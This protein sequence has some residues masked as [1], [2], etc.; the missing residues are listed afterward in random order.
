MKSKKLSP[1]KNIIYFSVAAVI[2]ILLIVVFRLSS[3]QNQNRGSQSPQVNRQNCLAEDCLLIDDLNY[4]AG[5]LSDSVKNSLNEAINDEYKAYSTYEAV[6]KKLG[7]VRPFSM[8]IRAEEQHI[9]ALKAIYD[10]YGLTAPA[11][12]VKAQAPTTLQQACQIGV[13]AEIANAA[14]YRDKLLPAVTQYPDITQV[15]NN[16]MNASQQKHLPAFQKCQ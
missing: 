6:I 12:T 14:L 2:I 11:N 4:P 7:N 13:D 8:I 1:N 3:T 5:E 9:S 16:L 15:F 10:K